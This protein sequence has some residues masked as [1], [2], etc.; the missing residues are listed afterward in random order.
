MTGLRQPER[1]GEVCFDRDALHLTGVGVD[2]ARKI[3][4][5]DAE[6]SP[7]PAA[8]EVQLL[9]P[10][11]HV[12]GERT[13]EPGSEERVDHDA[14]GRQP[15]K[16]SLQRLGH[17]HPGRPRARQLDD[18]IRSRRTRER[19]EDGHTERAEMTCDHQPVAAIV[20]AAARHVHELSRPAQVQ[21][22]LDGLAASA[23]H[24]HFSRHAPRLDRV[25][26]ERTHLRRAREGPGPAGHAIRALRSRSAR[27]RPTS[28]A[29]ESAARPTATRSAAGA[30]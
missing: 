15:P 24:Q 12:A 21:H 8:G 30:A 19:R 10:S 17:V 9:D 25:S 3:D 23:L 22:G 26:I 4:G 14:L 13:R 28:T 11:R 6:T 1:H 27:S 18:P 29:R 2:P 5:H 7:G 20:A 16:R